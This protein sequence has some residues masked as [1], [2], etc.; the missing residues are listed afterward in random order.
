[1]TASIDAVIAANRFGLGARPGE[2]LSIQSDP[3]GWLKAQ[4]QGARPVPP[5]LLALAPSD[6]VFQHQVEAIKARRAARQEAAKADTK[7]DA[8]VDASAAKADA[9]IVRKAVLD[10][11]YGQ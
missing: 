7:A 11:Y 1:M 2:L 10:N 3:R 4:V 5:A 8:T 6:Q 9:N